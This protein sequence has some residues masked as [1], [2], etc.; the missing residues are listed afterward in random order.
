MIVVS[1]RSS[2]IKG[3]APGCSGT[4]GKTWIER[5]IIGVYGVRIT[6]GP[7]GFGSRTE[8]THVRTV[9]NGEGMRSKAVVGYRN[10]LVTARSRRRWRQTARE[11]VWSVAPAADGKQGDQ[12]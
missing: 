7:V 5:G 2:A 10:L 1:P 3:K 9:I 11:R 12:Q 6:R 4:N 8:E